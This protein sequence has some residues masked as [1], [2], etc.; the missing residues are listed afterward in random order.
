M[1]EHYNESLQYRNSD[2]ALAYMHDKGWSVA[3]YNDYKQD[4]QPYYFWIFTRGYSAVKG[5]APNLLNAIQKCIHQSLIVEK[6]EEKR[7]KDNQELMNIHN[8]FNC[9]VDGT[10][11][12]QTSLSQ[13]V[14]NLI[15]HSDFKITE[16]DADF[17]NVKHLFDGTPKIKK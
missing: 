10:P 7:H 14:M 9:F 2:D 11:E 4:N 1:D 8:L 5:E 12:R 15:Q 17:A 6:L 13:K 16:D 3:I